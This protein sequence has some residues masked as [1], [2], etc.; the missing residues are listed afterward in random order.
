MQREVI[1]SDRAPLAIGPY[2]QGVRANGFLFCG[3]Q[4]GV[5]RDS[6]TVVPGGIAAETEQAIK[7][8]RAVIEAAGATL[9]D[10][11]KTTV[12]L[13]NIDDFARMNEVYGAYFPSNHPAR[14]T[15]AVTALPRGA[16][17][18]IEATVALPAASGGSPR[19]R[20]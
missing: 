11:V 9:Q 20:G 13:T 7:N 16:K 19:G 3:G 6:S 14:S 18:E 2:S 1:S 4:I 17:V 10:V 8:L 5:T 15:A 12:F